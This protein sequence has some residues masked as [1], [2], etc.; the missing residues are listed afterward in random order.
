MKAGRVEVRVGKV[1]VEGKV[2]V[3]EGLEREVGAAEER[4]AE[5]GQEGGEL[6]MEGKVWV[7]GVTGAGEAREMGAVALEEGA[8]T[9]AEMGRVGEEQ[10]REGKVWVVGVQGEQGVMGMG[11]VVLEVEG[12]KVVKAGW[13]QERAEWEG[14]WEAVVG[15]EDEETEETEERVMGVEA[16]WEWE[17][18]G[19]ARLGRVDVGEMEMEVKGLGDLEK[20]AVM[21]VM[22]GPL[23]AECLK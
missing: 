7:A 9:G 22:V 13:D 20:V 10:E 21:V 6:E 11:G 14:G 12:R 4:G 17:M 3:G 15:A 5:V 18:V 19:G 23:G 8:E 1:W 16:G 2:K